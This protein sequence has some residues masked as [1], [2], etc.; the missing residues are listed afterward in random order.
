MSLKL[1]PIRMTNL[2]GDN[3]LDTAGLVSKILVA[4]SGGIAE[5]GVGILSD[6]IIKPL[7]GELQK[8]TGSLLDESGKLLKGGADAGKG[9]IDG[10]KDLGKGI[11]EGIGGLLKPK[12]K[13]GE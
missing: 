12:K 10:G 4:L 13:E 1:K 8:L 9:I 2:G 3:K 6:D 5:Q 7:S 11:T